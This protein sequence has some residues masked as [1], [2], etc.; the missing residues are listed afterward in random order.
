EGAEDVAPGHHERLAD[1]Q[2][3]EDDAVPREERVRDGLRD[4]L[5]EL[6]LERR[7]VLRHAHE[8]PAAGRAAAGE[9]ATAEVVAAASR[10]SPPV[11]VAGAAAAGDLAE[12]LEA[13]RGDPTAGDQFAETLLHVGHEAPRARHDLVEEE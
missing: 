9:H 8:R 7:D 1:G 6:V 2:V 4:L 11:A 13:V 3:A 12:A 10:R 5:L